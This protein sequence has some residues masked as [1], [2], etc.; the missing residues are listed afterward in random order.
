MPH[1]GVWGLLADPRTGQRLELD[2]PDDL[3]PST[4]CTPAEALD[5][6]RFRVS[7]AEGFARQ[8]VAAGV[9]SALTPSDPE[10]VRGVSSL[11]DP[12][13]IWIELS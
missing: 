1:G 9:E 4:P 3:S 7:D 2:W 12:N 5:R 8:I 13:G 10:V 11:R 6:L